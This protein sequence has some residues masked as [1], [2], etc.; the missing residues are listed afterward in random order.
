MYSVCTSLATD[1][2]ELV[3]PP[4]PH[5]L[6]PVIPLTLDHIVESFGFLQKILRNVAPSFKALGRVLMMHRGNYT[7]AEGV[8]S[9]RVEMRGL[10]LL[11]IDVSRK[12]GFV[13]VRDTEAVG[14]E[15]GI[16]VVT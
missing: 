10:L 13:D 6:L 11:L 4:L 16:G 3:N 8:H 5:L 1:L 2:H 12:T 15:F 9:G 7:G 14:C